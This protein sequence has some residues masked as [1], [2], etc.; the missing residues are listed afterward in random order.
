MLYGVLKALL[1][2]LIVALVSETARRNAALGALFASLPLVSVLGMMWIWRDT[3]D[4]DRLAL[5]SMAT[6]WYVLPSLPMFLVMPLLWRHGV[7][8]WPGLG[9]GCMLTA[10]LYIAMVAVLSRL[11]ISL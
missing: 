11:G 9:L 2:G 7:A 4:I 5:H 10:A 8:F 6:F 3:G 1:S